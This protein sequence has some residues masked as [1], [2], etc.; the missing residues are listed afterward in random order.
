MSL[1][2]PE[3]RVIELAG[4]IY[5]IMSAEVVGM[6]EPRDIDLGELMFHVHAIQRMVGSQAAARQYPGQ[7][8]L[9]GRRIP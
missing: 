5:N 2:K 8:R 3:L 7:F 6:D 1:T 4:E 9:L